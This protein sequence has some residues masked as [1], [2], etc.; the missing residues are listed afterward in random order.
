MEQII[1]MNFICISFLIWVVVLTF[2][3]IAPF[4]SCVPDSF[5]Y[6]LA[7]T[8]WNWSTHN[9]ELFVFIDTCLMA[10]MACSFRHSQINHLWLW[11]KTLFW[12][13]KAST[14]WFWSLMTLSSIH[15][16]V[17]RRHFTY[18]CHGFRSLNSLNMLPIICI[19][20]AYNILICIKAL[21]CHKSIIWPD[22]TQFLWEKFNT[23]KINFHGANCDL[24]IS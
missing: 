14:T 5:K 10:Y 23:H 3:V 20:S 22:I 18:I 1:K 16:I 21:L 2:C 6:K 12:W 17:G 11:S 13:E 24:S 15:P 8:E 9:F 19:S 7:F 4:K